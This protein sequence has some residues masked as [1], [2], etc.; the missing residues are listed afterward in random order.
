MCEIILESMPSVCDGSSG[1]I[2]WPHCRIFHH[3]AHE[4]GLYGLSDF[5]DTENIL[6]VSIRSVK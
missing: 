6:V 3:T 1:L 4:M 2:K 5:K